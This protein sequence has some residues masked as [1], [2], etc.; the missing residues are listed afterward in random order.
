[1]ARAVGVTIPELEVP[2]FHFSRQNGLF[3]SL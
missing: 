3:P 2:S 1:L